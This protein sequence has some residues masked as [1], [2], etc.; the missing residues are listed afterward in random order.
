MSNKPIIECRDAGIRVS[1]WRTEKESKKGNKYNSYSFKIEKRYYDADSE[2]YKETR[3]FN[4]EE[5]LK[6]KELLTS[7][8]EG[9]KKLEKVESFSKTGTNVKLVVGKPDELRELIKRELEEK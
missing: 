8:Y 9:R 2:E 1:G 7:A 4:P 5:L 6:L 3:Y